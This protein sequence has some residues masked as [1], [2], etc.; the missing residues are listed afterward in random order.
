MSVA[1]PIPPMQQTPNDQEPWPLKPVGWRALLSDR[2]LW[3]AIGVSFLVHLV[4]LAPQYGI[5]I[6]QRGDKSV[7]VSF[8]SLN[9]AVA[10][11]AAQ[12]AAQPRKEAP[13]QEARA[14]ITRPTADAVAPSVKA[15]P[16]T[17]VSASTS[18]VAGSPTAGGRR[19]S[20]TPGM[21]DYRYSQYLEDWRLKV[22][23]IGAMN[24]PEEAR[25]KFFG[26]LVMSVALRPDGSVDRII[27]LRSSGNKVLDDAAKRIVT[28]AA[29]FAP[30]PPDIRKE[31]D[32]LDITRTW[33]FTRGN[34]VET[35]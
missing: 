17:D 31:T 32:Y 10:R 4:L 33:S 29:P 35:R 8:H 25:G 19:V 30:F 2:L 9:Q 21:K 26:T 22:E 6:P 15:T 1:Q 11:H 3:L 20:L 27:V 34:A 23:R 14:R 5:K 16:S 24:Y 28:I 13:P 12:S 18:S 7:L